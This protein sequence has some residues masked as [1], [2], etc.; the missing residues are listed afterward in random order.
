MRWPWVSR[1]A[2]D[3]VC[4]QRDRLEAK[5]NELIDQIARMARADR[6]MPELKVERKPPDPIPD[7]VMSI[8][9]RF[10]SS[11]TRSHLLQQ[12][13]QQRQLGQS[14]SAIE[15]HLARGLE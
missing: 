14:W 12:C 13:R 2:Y 9:N 10:Q 8:L 4:G 5:Q 1:R 6:G 3:E 7:G 15:E 11:S